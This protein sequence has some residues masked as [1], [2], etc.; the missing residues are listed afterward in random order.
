MRSLV[1]LVCV[2]A[3]VC[4]VAFAQDDR[5]LEQDLSSHYVGRSFD[6]WQPYLNR[7]VWYD[8]DGRI[9]ENP[10]PVCTNI[11]GRLQVTRVTVRDNQVMVEATRSGQRPPRMRGQEVWPSYA[12]REIV[13]RFKSDGQPWTADAFDQAFQTSLQ[14]RAKFAGLPPG[15]SQPPPDS[16]ARIVYM[17]NGAPVYSP[18]RGVTPPR[19]VGGNMDPEYTEAARRARAGGRVPLRFIVNEDGSVSNVISALP[20]L[21]YGLDEKS[22]EKAQQWRFTPGTLDGQPVKVDIRAETSFCVY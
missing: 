14:P 20:R 4:T 7:E 17:F 11:Y 8:H 3:A 19:Q 9:T 18:G 12:S 13:L 15:A 21:G 2:C 6:N 22:V 1:S 16:D 5:A 10:T